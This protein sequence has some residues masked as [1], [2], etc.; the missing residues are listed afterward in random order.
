MKDM[1]KFRRILDLPNSAFADVKHRAFPIH[2]K[3]H[4]I[5]SLVYIEMYVLKDGHIPDH[6]GDLEEW[7]QVHDHILKALK[8]FGVETNHHCDFCLNIKEKVVFI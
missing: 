3:A 8:K 7:Q 6:L 4:A 1:R 5:G 2:T